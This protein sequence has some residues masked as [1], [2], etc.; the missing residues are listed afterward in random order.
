MHNMAQENKTSQ[1]ES[2]TDQNQTACPTWDNM[3]K[4]QLPFFSPTEGKKRE[5]FRVKFLT[6]APRKE[7]VNNYDPEKPKPELWFDVTIKGETLTWTISQVSL[8]G[9]L[10]RHAPLKDKTFDI[11]LTQVTEEFKKQNPRYKGRDRYVVTEIKDSEAK[12]NTDNT[13]KEYH[14]NGEELVEDIEAII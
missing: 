1:A 6:D 13:D 8:L 5:G 10:K 11:K 12:D 4:E 7:T 3:G 9:E 14:A 2:G